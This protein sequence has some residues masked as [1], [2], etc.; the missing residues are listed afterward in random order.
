M[1]LAVSPYADSREFTTALDTKGGISMRAVAERP[2]TM[3]EV[4]RPRATKRDVCALALS[5]LR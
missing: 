4:S 2:I 5:Y 3:V 1:M